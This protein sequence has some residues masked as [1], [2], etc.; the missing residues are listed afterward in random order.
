MINTSSYLMLRL[1]LETLNYAIHNVFSLWK[2]QTTPNHY[3]T[4]FPTQLPPHPP[5]PWPPHPKASDPSYNMVVPYGSLATE[6]K[7]RLKRWSKNSAWSTGDQWGFPLWTAGAR[8][9]RLLGNSHPGY[10]GKCRHY[11]GH[12]KG[13]QHLKW[14]WNTDMRVWKELLS[15]VLGSAAG[16]NMGG[17][18][19]HFLLGAREWV[20]MKGTKHK[21][22]RVIRYSLSRGL[23]S[24]WE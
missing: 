21:M 11:P 9:L 14:R 7:G 17:L 10:W 15:S 12:G 19:G 22:R 5:L 6:V 20:G 2:C 18:R 3:T 4:A 23:M 8:L 24:T 16:F 13:A 1:L